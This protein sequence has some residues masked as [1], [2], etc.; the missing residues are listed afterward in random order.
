MM[1]ESATR[2]SLEPAVELSRTLRIYICGRT[3]ATCR[4][5]EYEGCIPDNVYAGNDV[6]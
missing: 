2:R 6:Y 3:S 5:C 4:G 1:P